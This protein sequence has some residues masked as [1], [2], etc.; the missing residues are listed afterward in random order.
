MHCSL[1][2]LFSVTAGVP[3]S[4]VAADAALAALAFVVAIGASTCR[5]A[6]FDTAMFVLKRQKFLSL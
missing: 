5:E 6:A 1:W 3:T 2:S 4:S